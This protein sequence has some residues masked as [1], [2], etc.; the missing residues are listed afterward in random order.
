MPDLPKG[1]K[2]KK[3][4]DGKLDIV[5]TNAAGQEYVARTTDEPGVTE[6]DLKILDIGNPEKRD[7]DAFV[8]FYRDERDNARKAWEHSQDEGYFEAAQQVV[9]AGLHKREST[10]GYSKSFADAWERLERLGYLN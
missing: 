1:L 6:R 8:G 7:A 2:A 10:A 4:A 3:R 5:G 9:H